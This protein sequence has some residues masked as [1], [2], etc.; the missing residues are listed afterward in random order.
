MK[1]KQA[2]SFEKDFVYRGWIDEEDIEG[3]DP[4]NPTHYWRT[5][6]MWVRIEDMDFEHLEN[7]VNLFSKEGTKIDPS[8]QDAFENVMLTYLRKKLAMDEMIERTQHDIL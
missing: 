1:M 7:T 6:M 4:P 8:R 3:G 5:R 2:F